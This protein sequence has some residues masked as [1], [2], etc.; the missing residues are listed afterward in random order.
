MIFF[1]YKRYIYLP[2][3]CEIP[4]ID[5]KSSTLGEVDCAPAKCV[6]EDPMAAL[7]KI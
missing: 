3:K 1:L 5:L 4:D 6:I 2:F 7:N